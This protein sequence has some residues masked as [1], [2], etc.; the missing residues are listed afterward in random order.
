MSE[1]R[2]VSSRI[3]RSGSEFGFD[4]GDSE[5]AG[6][7]RAWVRRVR[8]QIARNE[9]ASLSLGDE[10]V[11]TRRVVERAGEDDVVSEAGTWVEG[12]ETTS[13]DVTEEVMNDT[14]RQG[15]STWTPTVVPE[16]RVL[17]V[18]AEFGTTSFF[19]DV[20]AGLME[21]MGVDSGGFVFEPDESDRVEGQMSLAELVGYN[22][23]NLE[24]RRML[25]VMDMRN[26]EERRA[27]EWFVNTMQ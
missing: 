21:R 18:S 7:A 26:Y 3:A 2:E 25:L 20:A 17:A 6:R 12:I 9:G 5:G 27:R 1:Y 13:T 19:D 10:G 8:R 15:N 14:V 4:A 23:A 24:T 22:L 16:L 11:S